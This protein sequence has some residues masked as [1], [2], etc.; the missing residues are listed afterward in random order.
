[1]LRNISIISD[2]VF[3]FSNSW[4]SVYVCD[5][6]GLETQLFAKFK[7][8][9]SADSFKGSSQSTGLIPI[10]K[11]RKLSSDFKQNNTIAIFLKLW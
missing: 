3:A 8:K 6:L 5:A 7:I 4:N 10:G 2:L 1:M 9:L 11:K